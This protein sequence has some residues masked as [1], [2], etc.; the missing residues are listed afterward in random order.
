LEKNVNLVL[1]EY[2]ICKIKV[3]YVYQNNLGEYIAHVS[4]YGGGD[5][6]EGKIVTLAI[7]N[8]NNPDMFLPYTASIIESTFQGKSYES[9]LRMIESNSHREGGGFEFTL[10]DRDMYKDG[11]LIVN[12]IPTTEGKVS[13]KIYHLLEITWKRK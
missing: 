10:F 1:F 8:N 4:T 13:I 3:N 2:G 7:D 11:K 5:F 9:S 12:G 6:R